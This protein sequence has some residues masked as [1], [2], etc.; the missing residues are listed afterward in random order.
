MKPEIWGWQHITYLAI[1]AVIAAVSIFLIKKYVKNEKTL[2]CI[3]KGVAALLLA[4]VIWNRASIAVKN[5]NPM[6]L[7]PDSFCGISSFCLSL[8]LLIG[9]KNCRFFH[10][11]CY[12][13]FIGALLTLVYP[14]FIGQDESFWYPP[15]V[16]G[17]LHHTVMLYAIIL[18]VITG[19]FTPTIKRWY[20]LPIGLSFVLT[21]GQFLISAL[22]YDDAVYI[23][24]PLLPDSIF[25]WYF[26][27]MLVVIVS[28][29]IMLTFEYFLVWRKKR[30][31]DA[32]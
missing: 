3:L 8:S 7:I 15:T 29:L 2:V 1:F 21:F 30:G 25:T 14:D 22:G 17:L 18:M 32:E 11:V 9:K 6:N 16:S 13:G 5:S 4:S 26:T 24:H 20:C 23:N 10:F 31:A 12:V 27:G 28:L 19:Y